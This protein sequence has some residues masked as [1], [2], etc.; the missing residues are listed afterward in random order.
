MTALA[1]FAMLSHGWR[2]LLLMI[3]A[4]AIAGLSVPPL[5][6]L[7]A[8]FVAMPIWIWALDGAERQPRLGRIFGPA[9][10]IGWGFGLGYF[11]VALHWV[12]A[13]FLVDGGPLVYL[14]P[15]AVVVLSAG[16]AVFWGL[17]S[18]VAHL[19]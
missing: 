1:E 9:F 15:V 12:G 6:L 7:P 8:L 13:A 18:A 19:M 4:G 14:A 17:A 3:A 10:A 5:F 11:L 16:L 2:R